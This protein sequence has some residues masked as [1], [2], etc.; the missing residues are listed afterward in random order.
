MTI[1]NLAPMFLGLDTLLQGAQTQ[2]CSRA[3]FLQ[4]RA[5]GH[6]YRE[7]M[8]LRSAKEAKKCLKYCIKLQVEEKFKGF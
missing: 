5:R 2:I 6:H 3:T 8:S 1:I 4:N 7:K